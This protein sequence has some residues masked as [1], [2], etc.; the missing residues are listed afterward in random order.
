MRRLLWPIL[1]I[2]AASAVTVVLVPTITIH[3]FRPQTADGVE[4]SYALK[5]AAPAATATAL[6]VALASA[7]LLWGRV[8]RGLRSRQTRM[9]GLRRWGR[10]GVIVLLVGV[11]GLVTWFARQNHFE[12][13]FNALPKAEYVGVSEAR[14]FL[15]DAEV[16]MGID[17]NGTR[18]AYPV[19]Q[20][21][22]HHLVN[23]IVGGT[24]IVV[25]Y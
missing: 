2:A 17:V 5:R 19:R 6:A 7:L 8:E 23:E 21:A 11:T 15:V 1:F 22:Y 9:A 20:L 24:P 14:A 18:F 12:W 25:T 4:W 10:R 16:V 3:P 13:M